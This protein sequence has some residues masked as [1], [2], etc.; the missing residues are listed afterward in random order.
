MVAAKDLSPG[1]VILSEKPLVVGPCTDCRVQ[2]IACY[3]PIAEHEPY[4]RY[5]H[6]FTAINQF[7]VVLSVNNLCRHW[8]HTNKLCYVL[9]IANDSNKLFYMLALTFDM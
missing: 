4:V 9:N 3:H 1:D 6:L 8:H 7:N 5:L 2:C